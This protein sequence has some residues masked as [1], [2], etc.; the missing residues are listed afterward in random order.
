VPWSSES[1]LA[2]S[3]PDASQA[4]SRVVLPKPAAGADTSVN[5]ASATRFNR[6]SSLRRAMR[7]FR[8][9]GMWSLVSRIGR[10][11]VSGPGEAEF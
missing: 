9:V 10:I 8:H 3:W 11:M 2:C 4:A 7:P 6:S 1:Q 5:F